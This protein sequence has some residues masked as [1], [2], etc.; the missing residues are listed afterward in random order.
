MKKKA[1]KD[2]RNERKQQKA[3]HKCQIN[4]STEC[5]FPSLAVLAVLAIL[6]ILAISI[7]AWVTEANLI[8]GFLFWQKKFVIMLVMPQ[9][10]SMQII[11]TMIQFE[12]SFGPGSTNTHVS[13]D[14][15]HGD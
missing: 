12:F 6:A 8:I 13:T 9:F 5:V 3:R 14:M 11:R 15:R 4:R 10:W 2:D 7:V 1:R